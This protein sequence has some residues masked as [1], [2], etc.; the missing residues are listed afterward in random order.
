MD[1]VSL[2]PKQRVFGTLRNLRKMAETDDLNASR[3]QIIRSL[4]RALSWEDE[5]VDQ[6]AQKVY[7]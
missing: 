3:A 4:D 1:F 2:T 6:T 7:G 5:L